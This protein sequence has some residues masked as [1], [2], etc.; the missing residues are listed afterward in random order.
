MG[1][2][3]EFPEDVLAESVQ[4]YGRPR[5]G[6][7]EFAQCRRDGRAFPTD[8]PAMPQELFG[9]V[10]FESSELY[11][12]DLRVHVIHVAGALDELGGISKWRL[13][14]RGQQALQ[15]TRADKRVFGAPK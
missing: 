13:M 8:Y 11:L 3:P 1:S 12:E 7:P 14:A 10:A 15:S 4:R 2:Q 9:P 5:D 6:H